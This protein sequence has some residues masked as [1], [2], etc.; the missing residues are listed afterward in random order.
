MKLRNAKDNRGLD[1]LMYDLKL[2]AAQGGSTDAVS[3]RFTFS[4]LG[5]VIRL[6]P[7]EDLQYIVQDD[8]SAINIF[9]ISTQGSGVV[10]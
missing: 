6:K 2:I 1:N 8:L 10:N 9:E 3:G 7:L 5:A 4:K